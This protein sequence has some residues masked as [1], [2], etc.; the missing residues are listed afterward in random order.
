MRTFCLISA[1][2]LALIL[3]TRLSFYGISPN[4]T[5]AVVYYIG[6]NNAP[7][8]ALFWGSLIGLVEDSIAGN[9]LGP[10]LLGKGLTGFFSA[11]IFRG[12]F[13]WTP[14]MGMF[15]LASLTAMDSL[16]VFLSESIFA[17]M[18]AYPLKVILILLVQGVM[19]FTIGALL[20]PR[21]AD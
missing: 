14:V 20:K 16:A 19:N 4:L 8:K 9:I 1:A 2:V 13:I 10:H 15:G 5:A 3:Q 17:K 7:S 11:V 21:D 12:W 6:I 18:P